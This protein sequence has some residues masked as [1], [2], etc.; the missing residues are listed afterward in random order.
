MRDQGQVC[1]RQP[2]PPC[3][4]GLV[5]TSS[6]LMRE[7]PEGMGD[8]TRRRITVQRLGD[9]ERGVVRDGPSLQMNGCN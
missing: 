1:A 8:P 6:E 5:A 2:C 7:P 3:F 4:A 9:R